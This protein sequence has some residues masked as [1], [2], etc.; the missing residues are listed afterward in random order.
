[1]ESLL[2]LGMSL[3]ALWDTMIMKYPP[4][5]VKYVAM[6]GLC[7]L[8]SYQLPLQR[9]N[10]DH[11]KMLTFNTPLKGVQGGDKK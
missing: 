3:S 4:N 10:H 6:K 7:L 8:E 9:S 5:M 11:Y 1:M 2:D